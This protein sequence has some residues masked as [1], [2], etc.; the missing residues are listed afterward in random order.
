MTS[1]EIRVA[2][3][4]AVGWK[5]IQQRSGFGEAAS[6]TGTP[7][8]AMLADGWPARAFIP[9]YHESLD[10]MH[11][12][13]KALSE[14]EYWNYVTTHLPKVVQEFNVSPQQ[15]AHGPI[16]HACAPAHLRAKAFIQIILLRQ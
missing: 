4:T 10:A 5:N 11:E 9:L 8:D 3:A 7:T 1:I 2:I 13:E 14:A 12:A 16:S 15:V 6:L